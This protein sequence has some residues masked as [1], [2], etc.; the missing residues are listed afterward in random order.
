MLLGLPLLNWFMEYRRMGLVEHH[1][2]CVG[3]VF[4]RVLFEFTRDGS[5]LPCNA[6]F[7]RAVQRYKGR[8]FLEFLAYSFSSLFHYRNFHIISSS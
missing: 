1:E 2:T 8:N 3:M 5:I 7:K 6:L 4:V